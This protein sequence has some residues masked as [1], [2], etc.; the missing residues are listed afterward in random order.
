MRP[1]P[2]TRALRTLLG[3]AG[4]LCFAAIAGAAG[5]G[6]A[7]DAAAT[8]QP[9]RSVEELIEQHCT[10][11]HLAPKPRDLSREYWSFALHY[12]GNYVGMKGDE[13][14]DLTVSPVPPDWEPQQDYTKRYILS[15]SHGY[16]RD[17]YPFKAWIPPQ[18]EMSADEWRRMR[19]YYLEHALPWQEM[20]IK[21]PKAPLAPGFEPVVPPLDLE[22]NALVL[23]TRVDEKRRRIYVGR[24]V[25]DDWVGGGER[26]PGFDRWDDIVMLDLDSGKRLALQN[27]DS[28]PIHMT[29]TD[30][31]VRVLTHG[32]FPM[33]KVG[34]A[35]LTDWEF[36]GT[37]PRARMLV[38]GKQRFVEHQMADMN[39]DGL[40]DIVANAF[41]DGIA[42]DAQ[43]EL[44]IFWQTPEFRARWQDA[45]ATIPPGVLSGALRETIVSNQGGLI[46]SAV[47]DIDNDG[48]PDIAALVAQGRQ[49]LL[50]FIN[51]G[52]QTFTRH[53]I[54]QNTPSFG[55]NA[56]KVADFDGD[57]KLDL[58]VLNGDNVAGNHVGNIVPAP[59]PQH[60]VRVFR[61]LG[62]VKFAKAFHYPMHGAARSVIHDFDADGDPDIAVVSLFPQW[63]AAEPESFVYLENKGDFR[64]EPYS[65]ASEFF[66]VW[67]S[68][69][70]ADVNADGKTDIVLGLGD[71]PEL[72]PADWKT[73]HPIMKGRGGNAASVIYLI[74]R[75]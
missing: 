54:E 26:K 68:V 72:V 46:G 43:A 73:A 25:I 19:A 55:G 33:T 75:H 48:L 64:F 12:M 38:N 2:C 11:C 34:I 74:N 35:A 37:T 58:L 32:R 50:V 41:G 14:E 27:V 5:A 60:S 7:S 29:L 53:L 61:N 1:L 52:D 42:G 70:A 6:N 8:P 56:V 57:G 23:A 40:E 65:F 44:T 66:G 45:P 10:R 47:G 17:L 71:F 62:D 24:S 31:G 15:D 18:P 16:M 49:E 9:E 20:E 67:V 39:G 4:L 59:R 22:P 28:D 30:T 21:R 69:E 13:F 51:N 36:D 3:T 63:K